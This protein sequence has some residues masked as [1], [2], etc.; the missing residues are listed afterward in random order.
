MKIVVVYESFYG[1]TAEIA[2]AIAG[3]LRAAGEVAFG[4][5]DE[6]AAEAVRDADLIVA[7]GPTHAHGT[8]TIATRRSAATRHSKRSFRPGHDVLRDW[9]IDMP[10]VRAMAATFDTRFHK[11][12]WLTGS[13]AKGLARRLA[14]K[15]CTVIA[16]E[17]F[18]VKGT[19]GPLEPGER[20]RATRWGLML[21]E[22]LSS[23]HVA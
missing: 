12:R 20:E 1:D 4:H 11:P 9:L 8:A 6:I 7:G 17:S 2:E 18:F 21:A 23:K 5:I 15:G 10:D 3:G 13:A 19:E 14:S 16:T 22:R